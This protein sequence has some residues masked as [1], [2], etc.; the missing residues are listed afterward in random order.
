MLCS[1]MVIQDLLYC[2]HMPLFSDYAYRWGIG[3]DLNVIHKHVYSLLIYS[4]HYW[5][6]VGIYTVEFYRYLEL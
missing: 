4:S 2:V 6:L 3:S 5:L 1:D